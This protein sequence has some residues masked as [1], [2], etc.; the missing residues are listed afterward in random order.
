MKKATVFLLILLII[1]PVST[2]RAES[3][4]LI[5]G[6]SSNSVYYKAV[7][8]KR[9]VFPNEKI[10]YSWYADFSGVVTLSDEELANIPMGGNVFYKPNSRLVKIT[11][12]PKVYWVDKFGVLR[13]ILSEKAAQD[14]F[15]SDWISQIDDLPDVFFANY[16]I[17]APID[18]DFTI[19]ITEDWTID[20]NQ[21]LTASKDNQT[22]EEQEAADKEKE[23]QK[24][25]DQDQ[26]PESINLTVI[27]KNQD[28]VL[29]WFVQGGNVD[30]GFVIVK[31]EQENPSYPDDEYVKLVDSTATSY[32]WEN[33]PN[34]SALHFRIC[35]LNS[36]G[37]CGTYSDDESVVIGV[38]DKV[39]KITLNGS[40]EN[41]V[42][43]LSWDTEWLS[44][45]YGFYLVRGSNENPKYPTHVN[46]W[47]DKTK[48]SYDWQ[49]LSA[50][51]YYFRVCRYTGT[52]DD[53]CEYYSNNLE[54]T[55]E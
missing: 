19:E 18:S 5:K 23:S 7:D 37:T 16:T 43:K 6:E 10:Y 35:R 21:G 32:I 55:I 38:S 9:Y 31:S 47:L 2:A 39:P 44:P 51:T 24:T 50:G 53:Q 46:L 45:N 11:T 40:V 36:D 1:L 54:L 4:Q 15:G 33:L 13:H 52:T 28:A 49:G 22:Q 48:E 30:Y 14:L 20:D 29:S 27:V 3:G 26:Q 25:A 41:G 12:D 42:A 8:G 34:G 17:G